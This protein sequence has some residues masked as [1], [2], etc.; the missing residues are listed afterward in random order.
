MDALTASILQTWPADFK[1]HDAE[2]CF[3]VLPAFVT[4]E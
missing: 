3:R 1:M 2:A 4:D